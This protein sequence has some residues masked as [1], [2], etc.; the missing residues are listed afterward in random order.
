LTDHCNQFIRKKKIH[1]QQQCNDH[2]ADVAVYVQTK[3]IID[4]KGNAG[5]LDQPDKKGGND[6]GN[7][8]IK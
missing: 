6:P 2:N 3:N 7:P 8:E 4:R 1:E 5:V